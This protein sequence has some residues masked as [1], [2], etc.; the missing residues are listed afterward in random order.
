M[1]A[2][3]VEMCR[4][5]QSEFDPK[6]AVQLMGAT[7]DEFWVSDV[8]GTCAPRAVYGNGICYGLLCGYFPCWA[9]VVNFTIS[10]L[11]LLGVVA[12]SG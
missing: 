12:I 4:N 11:P 10:I 1:P 8:L 6:C 7:A 9:W 3:W 5:V 2:L